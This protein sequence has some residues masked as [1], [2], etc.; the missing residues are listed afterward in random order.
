[1]TAFLLHNAFEPDC[2][3]I[4]DSFQYS[5]NKAF[6]LFFLFYQ[7][8]FFAIRQIAHWNSNGST[9]HVHSVFDLYGGSCLQSVQHHL[10]DETLRVQSES[11]APSYPVDCHRADDFY[12]EQLRS[13]KAYVQEIPP[14][15]N[16]VQKL[17][18]HCP[19]KASRNRSVAHILIECLAS[20]CSQVAVVQYKV[21]AGNG[22]RKVLHG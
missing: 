17:A 8:F 13:A 6:A 4:R 16:D 15:Q 1:M 5:C 22:N 3:R 9:D 10:C 20:L 2:V 19:T 11:S 7:D 18:F 14:L 21:A 12:D